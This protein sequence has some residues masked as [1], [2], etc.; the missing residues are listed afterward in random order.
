MPDESDDAELDVMSRPR[1]Q[2]M[3][4][5]DEYETAPDTTGEELE[6]EYVWLGEYSCISLTIHE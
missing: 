1:I 5:D 4:D 6:E 2:D 3:S